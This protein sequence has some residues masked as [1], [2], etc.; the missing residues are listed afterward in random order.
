MKTRKPA[1]EDKRNTRMSRIIHWTG[2][3][4]LVFTS[5]YSQNEHF[6]L[7]TNNGSLFQFCRNRFAFVKDW[8]CRKSDNFPANFTHKV[9][10]SIDGVPISRNYMHVDATNQYL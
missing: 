8:A 3:E 2:C 5:V 9:D 4:N 6:L 10:G 1:S 7:S